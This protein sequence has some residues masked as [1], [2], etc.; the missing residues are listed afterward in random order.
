MDLSYFI[1][2]NKQKSLFLNIK[3]PCLQIAHNTLSKP[4]ETLEFKINQQKETFT[5]DTPLLLEDS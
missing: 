5:F 1:V 3:K 2:N 4:L